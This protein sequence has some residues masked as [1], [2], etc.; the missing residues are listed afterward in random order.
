M[1]SLFRRNNH[2]SDVDP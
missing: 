1:F 2:T